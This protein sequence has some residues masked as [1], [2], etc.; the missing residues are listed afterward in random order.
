MGRKRRCPE[1]YEVGSS[2]SESSTVTVEDLRRQQYYT[3][4]DSTI[5]TIRTRFAQKGLAMYCSLVD[6]LKNA[7]HGIVQIPRDVRL[8]Y[9]SDF[10]FEMLETQLTLLRGLNDQPFDTVANFV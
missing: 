8:T 2:R 7:S 6:I 4:L 5:S 10:D 3:I 1:R 9:D